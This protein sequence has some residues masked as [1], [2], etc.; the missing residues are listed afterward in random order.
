MQKRP[1]VTAA[2]K[3]SEF[4]SIFA[5]AQACPSAHPPFPTRK[6]GFKIEF[7]FLASCCFQ[8]GGRLLFCLFCCEET[9]GV[10]LRG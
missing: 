6:G 10:R 9:L 3:K 5:L 1:L 8:S 7:C 2:P 4:R